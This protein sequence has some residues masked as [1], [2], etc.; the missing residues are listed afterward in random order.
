MGDGLTVHEGRLVVE[1][2]RRSWCF[3]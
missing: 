3:A 2:C 1:V